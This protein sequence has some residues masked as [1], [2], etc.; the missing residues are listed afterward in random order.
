MQ[1][2]D[3]INY[4]AGRSTPEEKEEVLDWI[5]EDD[6]HRKRF[7]RLKNAW[8]ICNLPQT[9]ASD[10][11]ARR[12]SRRISKRRSI[13]IWTVCGIAASLVLLISFPI[14][15]QFE[16]YRQ[17]IL[18]LENQ[19]IAALEYHTNKGIKGYVTLPDGSKV[20][21][22][23]DSHIKCPGKFTGDQRII[24]FSGEGFFDVV[25]NPDRPMVIHLE[26]DISV[27]VRG[28][29]FNLSSYQNDNNVSAL[30]L[31]GNITIIR[32]GSRQEEIQVKPNEK[33]DIPKNN[34]TARLYQPKETFPTV[35]WKEGWLV[36]DETPV[37]EVLKKLERW[38]G[39]SFK[40]RDPEILN[41]K[42]TARFQE[43]S[44]SQILGMMEQVSL[45]HYELKE[46]TATLYQY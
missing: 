8:V 32:K 16:N 30:L 36:F 18:F 29:R 27:V 6:T 35:S 3:I 40:V 20:W 11:E 38:H 14:F 10:E 34:Q 22:N 9:H 41:Q 46:K 17:Q 42:F 43:E 4:I 28:T 23:S 7:N 24:E 33:I 2:K 26:N 5:E 25:K 39:I 1:E 12:Y 13:R 21:L 37:S 19:E 31:S 44:I 45:L 15:R